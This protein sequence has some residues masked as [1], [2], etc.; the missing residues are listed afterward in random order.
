MDAM[1][2]SVD[3]GAAEGLRIVPG[4]A[5]SRMNGIGS[6]SDL[7][8]R[9]MAEGLIVL[10]VLV[11]GCQSGREPSVGAQLEYQVRGRTGDRVLR[12]FAVFEHALSGTSTNQCGRKGEGDRDLWTCVLGTY[13]DNVL[14]FIGV[15]REM[16]GALVFPLGP[17]ADPLGSDWS[18]WR[19]PA[20]VER[21]L[22]P[23]FHLLRDGGRSSRSNEVPKEAVEIRFRLR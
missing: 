12:M 11:A 20:F 22:R 5:S 21:S 13:D 19:R 3:Q 9:S 23:D 6:R 15:R 16:G 2:R 14:R 17:P 10:C 1:H 7:M 8:I 18:D 4:V